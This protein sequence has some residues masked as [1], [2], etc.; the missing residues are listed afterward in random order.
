MSPPQPLRYLLFGFT[1][2]SAPDLIART[3]TFHSSALNFTR[4][5]SSPMHTSWSLTSTVGQ[6]L[7]AGHRDTTFDMVTL[8]LGRVLS[9]VSHLRSLPAWD[10]RRSRSLRANQASLSAACEG[11]PSTTGDVGF[12]CQCGERGSGEAAEKNGKAVFRCCRF[13]RWLGF[14]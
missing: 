11:R 2:S 10:K 4:L 7:Q 6:A 13:L 1:S 3:S 14:L 12:V 9:Y 5:A 8:P